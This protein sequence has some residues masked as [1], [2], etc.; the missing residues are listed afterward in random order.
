MLHILTARSML[1]LLILFRP[2][3][4]T[5]TPNPICGDVDG[6]NFYGHPRF[7]DCH[8]QLDNMIQTLR[9][10]FFG[11][12]TV[13]R[14]PR[15]FPRG[16][17]E[18]TTYQWQGKVALPEI[19]GPSSN[20]RQRNQLALILYEPGS[21]WDHRVQ[22]ARAQN[23]PIYVPLDA[24]G[25]PPVVALPGTTSATSATSAFTATPTV[26]R[27]AELTVQRKP[28]FKPNPRGPWGPYEW[29][30]MGFGDESQ[31]PSEV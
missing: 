30:G 24:P 21:E 1:T 28:V 10:R 2:L 13:T 31:G 17:Y 3:V 12:P 6:G 11:L 7:L 26:E 27:S 14:R 9:I 15:R 25:N 20:S 4:V 18:I 19:I 23:Q 8:T 16:P 5:A 29:W 22:A